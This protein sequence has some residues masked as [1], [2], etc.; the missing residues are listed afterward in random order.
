MTK[1][2]YL[3]R[4]KDIC[5][6]EWFKDHQASIILERPEITI[7]RWEKPDNWNYGVRYI[8]H[9]RWLMVVGDIGEATYEWGQDITL[10][11]LSEIDFHYFLGKCR[12]SESGKDFLTWDG[13]MAYQAIKDCL[14]QNKTYRGTHFDPIKMIHSKVAKE[15]YEDAVRRCYEEGLEPEICS[16]LISDA[17]VPSCRAVGHFTGLQMAINQIFQDA[18]L[19]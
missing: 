7:L 13:E 18:K 6:L 10:K 9:R 14:K 17:F 16:S 15:E 4:Q 2:E 12:S 8:I 3:N 1:Q 11:F 19:K 5:R